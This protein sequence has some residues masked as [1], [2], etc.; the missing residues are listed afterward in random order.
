MSGDFFLPRFAGKRIY[1]YNLP[2]EI[3]LV[4]F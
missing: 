2:A 3:A 1:E 4:P